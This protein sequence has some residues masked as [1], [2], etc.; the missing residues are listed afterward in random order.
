LI[1]DVISASDIQDAS[2]HQPRAVECKSHGLADVIDAY[3]AADGSFRLG[4]SNSSSNS[5]IP[6]AARVAS[7]PGEMAWTR[8]PFG[9]TSEAIYRTALS[10]AQPH[11]ID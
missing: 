11:A 8:M 7:G 10:M 4:L 2:R 9:P 1:D 3:Q 6:E 5:G